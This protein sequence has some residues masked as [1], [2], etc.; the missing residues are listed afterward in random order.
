MPNEVGHQNVLIKQ[1]NNEQA[2]KLDHQEQK[3][4]VFVKHACIILNK[5]TFSLE[6]PMSGDFLGQLCETFKPTTLKE[7]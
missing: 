7:C 2:G 1:D 4:E 5:T 6:S 3:I